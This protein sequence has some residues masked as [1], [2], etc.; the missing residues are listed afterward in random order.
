MSTRNTAFT[1]ALFATLSACAVPPPPKPADYRAEAAT[2]LLRRAVADLAEAAPCLLLV[3]PE[4]K[5]KTGK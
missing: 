4:R 3:A 5:Y 1:L 2:E